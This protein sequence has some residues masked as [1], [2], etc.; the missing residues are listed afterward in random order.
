MPLADRSAETCWARCQTT[1]CVRA[2]AASPSSAPPPGSCPQAASSTCLRQTAAGQRQW[3]IACCATSWC[4]Q[5]TG[6]CWSAAATTTA[7]QATCLLLQWS[8]TPTSR[9]TGRWL[10]HSRWGLRTGVLALIRTQEGAQ[11]KHAGTHAE[12]AQH[13]QT[14]ACTHARRGGTTQTDAGTHAH[15]H[16]EG[17]HY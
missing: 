17:A 3:H 1:P 13:K 4:R 9:T 6:C 14:H 15:T 11:H 5:G 7:R 12:G 16:V 2:T 10:R 8:T